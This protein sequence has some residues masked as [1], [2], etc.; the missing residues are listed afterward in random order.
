MTRSFKKELSCGA[1]SVGNSILSSE[2]SAGTS[3]NTFMGGHVLSAK[4]A[5]DPPDFLGIDPHG[6][7]ELVAA[8]LRLK[9]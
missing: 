7:N 4:I 2:V 9:T 8:S 6:L 1:P 3:M 5:H